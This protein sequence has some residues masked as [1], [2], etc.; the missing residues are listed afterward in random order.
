MGKTNYKKFLCGV[1]ATAVWGLSATC[2]VAQSMLA[3]KPTLTERI[4]NGDLS[5]LNE[6]ATEA[7]PGIVG[8]LKGKPQLAGGLN[9]AAP[10]K[11]PKRAML[12]STA[13]G[14][15]I[16]GLLISSDDWTGSTVDDIPFGVYR[17]NTADTSS[18]DFIGNVG[19]AN[20][21]GSFTNNTLRYT[22]YGL[23]ATLKAYYY[24]YDLDTWKTVAEPR[25]MDGHMIS[26]CSAFDPTTYKTYAVY[27]GNDFNASTWNFGTIDY[28]L[29]KTEQLAEIS[30][31]C[32]AM[33]FN[34]EGELYGITADG[35]LNKIDT[36]TGRFTKIG[37]TSLSVKAIM[38][39]A[40][41]DR[42]TGKMYWAAMTNDDAA[43]LYEVNTKTG[44]AT[45]VA[46][47]PNREEPIAL[48]IP[49]KHNATAPAAASNL[50]LTFKGANTTGALQF[51][52]PSTTM[53]GKKLSGDLTYTVKANGKEI[54][55][56]DAETA[57]EQVTVPV[58]NLT[59]GY[60]TF[61]VTVGNK[62][63]EGKP[64]YIKKW[65][66]RDMP[67]LPQSVQFTVDT[68]NNNLTNLT[69]TAPKAGGVH[70]GYADPSEFTYTVVRYPEGKTV[71]EGLKTRSFSENVPRS[72]W[73]SHYYEV[74]AVNNGLKSEAAQSNIIA[75]GDAL[76]LPYVNNIATKQDFAEFEMIG[77]SETN[78]WYFLSS[79][80]MGFA[81]CKAFQKDVP[82]N[83]WLITPPMKM[84]KGYEYELKFQGFANGDE[85]EKLGVYLWTGRD[86]AE[87]KKHAIDEVRVYKGDCDN[88]TN[89]KIRFSVDNDGEYRVG[90]NCVSDPNSEYMRVDSVSVAEM[91]CYEAPDSVHN[92]KAVAAAEG[93]QEATISFDAPTKLNNGKA[94]TT[95]TK[96]EV[97]R[98]GEV[99]KTLNNPNPGEH[100]SVT[101][102]EAVNG[103]TTY[104]VVA[105]NAAGK[106]V[107]ASTTLYVGIDIPKKPKNVTLT[108]NFDGTVTLSWD[109]VTEG[110][111]NQ[112]VPKD[113]VT[114]NIYTIKNGNPVL[115][116]GDV[117]GTSIK[118]DGIPQTGTQ[119]RIYYGVQS[120]TE[121][122]A[123]GYTISNPLLSGT[124]Y[125]VP[126]YESFSNASQQSGPWTVVTKGIGKLGITNT[127]T[128]DSDRG[129]IVCYP[130]VLGFE[131]FMASPKIRMSAAHH[132]V[133]SF[134]YYCTPGKDIRIDAM[135]IRNGCDTVY[136]KSFNFMQETGTT[137][138][139]KGTFDLNE[140]KN[141]HYDQILFAFE[142]SEKGTSIL[143]DNIA[144]EDM[145]ANDLKASIAIPVSV[146]TGNSDNA[147]VTVENI[148][149][150]EASGYTIELY[151]DNVVVDTKAGETL[152]AGSKKDY[153]LTFK[154]SNTSRE[155]IVLRAKVVY[156]KDENTKNNA[157]ESHRVFV[158]AP[159]YPVVSDLTAEEQT[160][161]WTA[162]TN[163][164]KAVTDGFETYY[165]LENRKVG[166]W[167]MVDGDEGEPYTFGLNY[168]E[169]F[170]APS[171]YV[172]N[173][174][175]AIGYDLEG[176][177]AWGPH[178]G[179]QY[180]I[181]FAV[182]A[183]S[184]AKKHNDDWLISPLLSGKA[185]TATAW[186]KSYYST[187]GAETYELLY[188]T[189]GTQLSDFVSLGTGEAPFD[190]TEV[191]IPLPDGAK[192]FA[193]RHISEDKYMFMVDDITYVPGGMTVKG[194]NIYRDGKL[195]GT[196]DASTTTFL[197]SKATYGSH[198][199]VV[200]VLY[201]IGESGPSNEATAICTGID[202]VDATTTVKT[203]NGHI[204]VTGAAGKT[205]EI[206]TAGGAKV[207]YATGKNKVDAALAAGIYVVKVGDEVH[208]VT[209]AR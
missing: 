129:A 167:T 96:I 44:N 36:Q 6:R 122:G 159:T 185:Q 106:G 110:I 113:D 193:I 136:V 34:A 147:T 188:S 45:F 203:L 205:V 74:Y 204:I 112:F 157:T 169:Q 111:N 97:S 89:R 92:L 123:E 124:P 149:E 35:Y 108:D 141:D 184:T 153:A 194:Y 85:E 134:Y 206:Y 132:P 137:G 91:M 48:Y 145:L 144:I 135:V 83:A 176:D 69:W 160:V 1:M 40:V 14:T 107:P 187:Y 200:T 183:S 202:N 127:T 82:S 86:T 54:A 31:I 39:S 179:N 60:N 50:T 28:D 30:N 174:P 100:L 192:Y 87:F 5:W 146:R 32:I 180:M 26:V 177:P 29:E 59:E 68:D 139:R 88:R 64:A 208:N 62:N 155:P 38:Q 182:N 125:T 57:E 93:L 16:W 70:G 189:K 25:T 162:M 156:D 118:I 17:F 94:L 21:G 170:R 65:I 201:E 58:R 12:A 165:P 10:Q 43:G 120:Q 90:F 42:N 142:F 195:V 191:N 7:Y 13:D 158:Y 56:G 11:A 175:L 18:K 161:R 2:A 114:Y 27:Y 37:N 207:F 126:Y 186:L 101:D 49:L 173:N 151:Q 172:V 148:G 209:V 52:A 105:H 150:N 67:Q 23:E 178:T 199:Y 103:K 116:K 164:D 46:D 9:V 66:G 77:G 98:D 168:V 20:G 181:S 166:D 72:I 47:F 190:W 41:F 15:E 80:S 81:S 71:A 133:A 104:E 78:I 73:S 8:T 4:A 3:P 51:D 197:D 119:G 130:N 84:R 198:T 115:M 152:A 128:Q 143:L 171:A 140:F 22:S 95:I 76:D 63:G 154:A 75:F 196:V 117:S 99:F 19:Y 79:P 109:P 138:Y 121:A 55:D 102:E 131:G 24:E 33:A 163:T 61:E 53:A